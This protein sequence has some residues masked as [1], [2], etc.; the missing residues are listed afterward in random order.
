MSAMPAR[1]ETMLEP[2]SKSASVKSIYGDPISAN[3]K[4]IIPVARVAYGFGG[5]SGRRQDPTSPGEGEGGGG[6]VYA[7]PAGVLEVTESGTRFIDLTDKRKLAAA[8]LVGFCLG[9]FWARSR[10]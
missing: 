10:G 6:G 4:T 3:G 9:A 2:I 7:M 5:G 1:L 8:A